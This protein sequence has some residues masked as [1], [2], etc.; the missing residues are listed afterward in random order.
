VELPELMNTQA[1]K[2]VTNSSG[3]PYGS[4]VGYRQSKVANFKERTTVITALRGMPECG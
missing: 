1:N 4:T 2:E 3:A